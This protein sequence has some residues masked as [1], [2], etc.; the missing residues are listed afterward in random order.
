MEH[1]GIVSPLISAGL[2]DVVFYSHGCKMLGGFYRAGGETRRPTAILLHGVPGVEQ[3]LDI[4]YALRDAGWNCLYFHYRGCWGS[5]GDY[6]F[7]NLADDVFA[8]A[9][10]VLSQEAVDGGELVLVGSSMGG[11]AALAAGSRDPRFKRLVSICPLVDPGTTDLVQTIFD[12]WADMLHGTSGQVLREQWYALPPVE[13]MVE[14]L[15]GR[16]ILLVSGDRDELFPPTHYTPLVE[17]LPGITWRRLAGGDHAFS[18]CRQELV[19]AVVGWLHNY[20]PL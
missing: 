20:T 6:S 3:N 5:Q 2:D 19:E 1:R 12:G 17:K 14:G 8:A 15:A 7:N 16:D 18:L 4:A 11:Y 10:W 13:S 9:Q